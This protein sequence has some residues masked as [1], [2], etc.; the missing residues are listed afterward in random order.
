MRIFRCNQNTNRWSLRSA[1]VYGI[2]WIVAA[3]EEK[4]FWVN[5]EWIGE[6]EEEE[7]AGNNAC[8]QLEHPNKCFDLTLVPQPKTTVK[9]CV[10]TKGKTRWC[11]LSFI[12]QRCATRYISD[13]I[14]KT[15]A[16]KL[17][18]RSAFLQK[19]LQ[20]VFAE[21]W[22]TLLRIYHSS[23]VFHLCLC[24]PDVSFGPW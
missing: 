23:Q 17:V 22:A 16:S 19:P 6:R 11:L 15:S 20:Y 21:K 13:S 14:K 24:S 7:L 2:K 12:G 1:D 9:T 8:H 18:S 3:G 5:W 4:S 10:A